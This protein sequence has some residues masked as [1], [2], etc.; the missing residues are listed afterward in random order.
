MID[1]DFTKEDHQ[2]NFSSQSYPGIF[3]IFLN[4]V[5]EDGQRYQRV[6]FFEAKENAWLELQNVWNNIP[7]GHFEQLFNDAQQYPRTDFVCKVLIS[8]PLYACKEERA[9]VLQEIQQK[10]EEKFPRCTYYTQ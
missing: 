7:V 5:K 1:L 9:K 10:F 3:F 2:Y 8:A 6:A 4:T